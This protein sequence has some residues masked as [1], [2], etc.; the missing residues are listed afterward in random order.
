MQVRA[1]QQDRFFVVL[2]A[3]QEPVGMQFRYLY[4]EAVS[5]SQ[6]DQI[7]HLCFIDRLAFILQSKHNSNFIHD[8][9]LVSQQ[10]SPVLFARS[11]YAWQTHPQNYF[12]IEQF[13]TLAGQQ[14][15]GKAL[16]FA[17][18]HLALQSFQLQETLPSLTASDLSMMAELILCLADRVTVKEVDWLEWEDPFVL[19]RDASALKTERENSFAEAQKRLAYI[20]PTLQALLQHSHNHL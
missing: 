19:S 10:N 3:P 20:I 4:Q 12:A 9:Q 6:P 5:I 1:L 13:A 17:W 2:A 16:D 14:L 8:I 18:C 15:F 7:L 11:A